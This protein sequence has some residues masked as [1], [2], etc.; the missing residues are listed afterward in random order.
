M[1]VDLRLAQKGRHEPADALLE[2]G[3][4][5]VALAKERAA[6]LVKRGWSPAQTETLE[7]DVDTFGASD[8]AREGERVGA[9]TA[10]AAER[11][12]IA[13]VKDFRADLREIVPIVLRKHPELPADAFDPKETLGQSTSKLLGYLNR[14]DAVVKNLDDELAPYF[15]G[16]KPSLLIDAM[17]TE[18]AQADTTQET[19]LDSLP[20]ATLALYELAGRILEQIE[21]L[22]R[23][24][25]VAHRDEP[26]TAARFNKDILKRGRSKRPAPSEPAS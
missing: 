24:G 23:I 2:Q 4:V 13:A 17:R 6:A 25:R 7:R 10:H 14:I 12:A 21:D 16:Q 15:E 8:V 26:A 3:R 20:A 1:P 18:L 9:R 11:R 22:N 5:S 19:A